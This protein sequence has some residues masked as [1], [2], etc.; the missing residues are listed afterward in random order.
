MAQ[1]LLSK[2]AKQIPDVWGNFPLHAA[3]ATGN[4][5]YIKK[6]IARIANAVQ[7][8]VTLNCQVTKIVMNSGSQLSIVN[9][10][11]LS[12]LLP[13]KGQRTREKADVFF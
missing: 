9:I 1:M 4:K 7:S 13:I 2:G 3:C 5:Y 8:T 12:T 11:Y 6:N 10:C